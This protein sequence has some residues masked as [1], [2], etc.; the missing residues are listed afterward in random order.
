[1]VPTEEKTSKSYLSATILSSLKAHHMSGLFFS[2]FTTIM[3]GANNMWRGIRYKE[4]GT[5]PEMRR[6]N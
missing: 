3:S 4:G 6:G 5:K 1:M 2:L